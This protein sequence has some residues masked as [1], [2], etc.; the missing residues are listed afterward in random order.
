M[1]N[2][3]DGLLG[4]C[5]D[6]SRA[7][8]NLSHSKASSD[9]K[10]VHPPRVSHLLQ[11]HTS[12]NRQLRTGPILVMVNIATECG[13]LDRWQKWAGTGLHW[14]WAVHW[15]GLGIPISLVSSFY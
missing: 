3:C 13:R 8:C 2:T 7:V 10:A 11:I 12:V 1:E 4:I 15:I 14:F 5:F 9:S 6:I